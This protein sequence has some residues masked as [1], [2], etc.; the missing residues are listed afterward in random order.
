MWPG[1]LLP[2]DLARSLSAGYF[3]RFIKPY[4]GA[5]RTKTTTSA[6][7][8][9]NSPR[10]LFSNL[11]DQVNVVLAWQLDHQT[12]RRVAWGDEVSQDGSQLIGAHAPR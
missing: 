1:R 2:T 7:R 5:F 3:E 8:P 10:A 9:G 4:S 6:V 12:L 11:P